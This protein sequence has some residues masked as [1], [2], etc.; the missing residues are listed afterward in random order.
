[1]DCSGNHEV[2]PAGVPVQ[3]HMDKCQHGE[4]YIC[5]SDLIVWMDRLRITNPE[6][7]VMRDYMVGELASMSVSYDMSNIEEM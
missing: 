1:M 6:H 5:I 4:A 3:M 7:E 2:A